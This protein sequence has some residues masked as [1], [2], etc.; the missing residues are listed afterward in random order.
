MESP[1]AIGVHTLKRSD[2]S[3]I[4][5][6]FLVEYMGWY[7]C[8]GDGDPLQQ[9]HHGWLQW[10]NHQ[11]PDMKHPCVDLFPDVSSYSPSELYPVPGLITNTNQQTFLFSSRNPITVQRHFHWMAEYGVDGAFFCRW[12]GS[13]GK[14]QDLGRSLSDEVIDHVR[15]AAEKEDRVFAIEYSVR[16]VSA[17]NVA[18]ADVLEQDWKNLV[19][20]KGMLNSPN[21]LREN[22]KPIILL[23]SLGWRGAGHTPALVRS[24][25]AVFRRITPGDAYIMGCVPTY[26]RTSEVDADPNPEF[27][28]VWLD[29][30]DAICPDISTNNGERMKADMEFIRKRLEGGH[31]TVDYIPLVFPGF[32]RHNQSSGSDKWNEF[33][34]DG[35]RELWKEIFNVSKL[36]VRTMYGVSWD[37]YCSGDALLPVVPQKNLLPQSNKCKFMALD[38]DGY[39]L[40][41]D[42]YMRICGLAAEVLHNKTLVSQTFPL[43]ELLDYWNVRCRLLNQGGSLWKCLI[44]T[45]IEQQDAQHFVDFLSKVLDDATLTMTRDQTKQMLSLLLRLSRLFQVFPASYEL[46][47]IECDL[48]KPIYE[49]GFGYVCK[50]S[51]K[52]HIVCVKAVRLFQRQDSTK[53]LQAL[54]KELILWS[55]LSHPNVVPF[56]GV[57][58]PD[59][60]VARICL[61]SPWMESGNLAQYLGRFP[62]IPQ[63]LLLS[64]VSAGLEF[65]HRSKIIHADLKACN[66]LVSDD[67]R[68][69]ITDFGASHIA[70]TCSDTSTQTAISPQ[71]TAPELFKS[72]RARPTQAS[73]VWAF[74]CVI[75]E[76]WMHFPSFEL[77]SELLGK[78]T[79][80]K[81]PFYNM[82]SLQVISSLM[83][84]KITPLRTDP[85]RGAI[86]IDKPLKTLMKRCW[87]YDEK[88]RPTA[89]AIDQFFKDLQLQ[90]N[91]PLSATDH[92]A[93]TSVHRANAG[94]TIDYER[95]YQ[96]LDQ[97]LLTPLPEVEDEDDDDTDKEE[98]VEEVEE[99]PDESGTDETEDE[100]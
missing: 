66:V 61:V 71:W 12:A 70:L 84:G 81:T 78:V 5:D 16:E 50:A 68:A 9:S 79:T 32:S 69:M 77:Y 6:K 25:V 23:T 39:D 75:Y 94:I 48:N 18:L 90:D 99:V 67:G 38:E 10:F 3:T 73:D 30:L 31:K 20:E 44:N 7:A 72:D 65:L 62:H 98:E 34:R 53:Q 91:R 82:T 15:E 97:V 63:L 96:I 93:L 52:G 85:N 40:P 80:G 11:F 22:G 13:L 55:H 36:G 29:E 57:W 83:K 76:V 47:G 86:Q 14:G 26:W 4:Q 59:T 49:G 64:D 89:E 100:E 60:A 37:D 21:Y 74:G 56:Y 54:A 2:P 35:G 87:I 28:D 33:K 58:V 43:R 8:P 51:H 19:Y 27:V 42:W 1:R 24:I 46:R 17:N 88:E 95:V 41:S 45:G 92:F